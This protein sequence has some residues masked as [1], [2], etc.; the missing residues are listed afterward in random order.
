MAGIAYERE[1][2][3]VISRAVAASRETVNLIKDNYEK[4]LVNF[5][6][7]LDAERTKFDTEDQE[8]ISRGQ[9]SKNYII[10]YKALGGGTETELIP[11]PPVKANPSMRKQ[12]PAH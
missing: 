12:Q 2:L 6:N 10:L 1:R 3:E 11:G 4:G 7:V 9:I 8:I 5:Q